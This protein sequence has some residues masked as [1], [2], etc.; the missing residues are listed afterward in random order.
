MKR[1]NILMTSAAVVLFAGCSGKYDPTPKEVK[2]EK[3][4]YKHYSSDVNISIKKNQTLKDLIS[5]YKKKEA[6]SGKILL[7]KTRSNIVFN[8]T[9]KNMS[10][11]DFLSYI[12]VEYKKNIVLRKYTNRVYAIEEI[13]KTKKDFRI[14][15]DIN[16]IKNIKLE[17]KGDT[18]YKELFDQLRGQGINIYT[19]IERMNTKDDELFSDS[20]KI[21]EFKGNLRQF[22]KALSAKENLYITI[23]D[24]AICLKNFETK[25][26]D[27]KLPKMEAKPVLNATGTASAITLS[28]ALSSEITNSNGSI[29]S[30]STNNT[31]GEANMDSSTMTA[32]SPLSDLEEEL[33]AIFKD[34]D[35]VRYNINK[36]SGVLTAKASA[37][38]ME[39][40]QSIIQ[41]FQDIYSK[42]IQIEMHVYEI[43]LDDQNAFGIDYSMLQ[44][45]LVGNGLQIT[46]NI[47]TTLGSILP[48]NSSSVSLTNNSGAILKVTDP[49]TGDITSVSEKTAGVVFKFLN[50]FG[51]AAVLTKPSLGTVNNF[52]VSLNVVDSMDYVYKISQTQTNTATNGTATNVST[53][54]PE[55]KTV[56]TGFSLV[57]HPRIENDYIKIAMKNV[58]SNLNALNKYTYNKT[59][60]KPDGDTIQLKDVSAREF[61]ETVKLKEGEVAIIGGYQYEKRVSNKNGLPFTSAADSAFDALTSAKDTQVKK[62][63]IVITLQAVAR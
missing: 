29:D 30:Q 12:K 43:T 32:V 1:L 60:D 28:S 48:T 3:Y 46:R 15:G 26:F 38:D 9:I 25:T 55:I 10:L 53:L 31:N 16:K 14:D 56:Q 42:H 36:S 33:D 49:A 4:K 19:Q 20:E 21:G 11:K 57:L 13:V 52:P 35:L 58:V 61:A 45:E 40:I 5:S 51:R 54:D 2:V 17:V 23:N 39:T 59:A 27:L 18:T 41:K 63:E 24:G 50:K 8:E 62:V 22:I 37:R 34:N 6:E 7:D 44:Q 47:G